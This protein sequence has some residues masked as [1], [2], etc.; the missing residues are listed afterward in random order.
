MLKLACPDKNL[1]GVIIGHPGATMRSR[2][3]NLAFNRALIEPDYRRQLLAYL[4]QTLSE[5]GVPEDEIRQL[6]THA[7]KTLEN[8]ALA[9]EQVHTASVKN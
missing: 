7:P 4:R 2:A 1:T 3:L 5:A 6:E 9:M 8:L